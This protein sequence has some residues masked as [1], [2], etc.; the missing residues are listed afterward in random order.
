M[1]LSEKMQ[2]LAGYIQNGNCCDRSIAQQLKR[3]LPNVK[4]LEQQIEKMRNC[5]NCNNGYT[6]FGS[7]VCE[8]NYYSEC[9]NY[10]FKYW[11][12]AE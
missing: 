10:N 9:Y 11:E 7:I 8:K 5:D 4:K 12:L 2:T 1:K 6:Y 3:Y